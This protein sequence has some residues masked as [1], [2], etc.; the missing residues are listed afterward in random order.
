MDPQNSDDYEKKKLTETPEQK[1]R[2]IEVA[3][4]I[5]LPDY[6]SDKELTAFTVLDSEKFYEPEV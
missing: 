3:A 1:P 2:K 4:Q 6:Q 5:L